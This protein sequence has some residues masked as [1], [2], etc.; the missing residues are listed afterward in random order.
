MLETQ[1][2]R[3]ERFAS[4]DEI[5]WLKEQ[6]ALNDIARKVVADAI[7]VHPTVI[8]K[9]L[10]GNRKLRR[11]EWNRVRATILAHAVDPAK[12]VIQQLSLAAVPVNDIALATDIR[13]QR[14]HELRVGAGMPPTE[15]EMVQLS[16]FLSWSP[17]PSDERSRP[18]QILR[19]PTD[20]SVARSP[21]IP[22]FAGLKSLGQGW[23]A[24]TIVEI[25]HRIMPALGN[26]IG[27]YGVMVTDLEPRFEDGEVLIL[28]PN[29]PALR[30]KWALVHDGLGR[31]A[32]GKVIARDAAITLAVPGMDVPIKIDLAHQDARVALVIGTW[33][34]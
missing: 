27:A 29:R 21:R 6:M 20:S 33:T 9:I 8:S 10:H 12:R 1:M 25:E 4:P 30:G 18:D 32:V 17:L 22:V 28:H 13:P 11:E 24:D 2:T 14:I 7:E 34:E 16:S 23:F 3:M 5:L 26:I 31:L 15:R 19:T